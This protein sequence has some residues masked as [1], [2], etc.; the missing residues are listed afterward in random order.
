MRVW[1]T[2]MAGP[3][4]WLAHF[5]FVYTIPSLAAVGAA[6]ALVLIVIHGLVTVAC[7]VLAV[8]LAAAAWPRARSSGT[9][10]VFEARLGALGAGL[11]AI[12]IVWQATPAFIELG[13]KGAI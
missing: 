11:A 2:L 8:I 6:P 3:V 9:E 5:A 4:I 10:G 13:A 7:L 1:R 12:A